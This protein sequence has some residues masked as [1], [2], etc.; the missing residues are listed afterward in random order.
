MGCAF[1][2]C[3]PCLHLAYDRSP[4]SFVPKHRF[5]SMTDDTLRLGAYR[6]IDAYITGH[7]QLI[8]IASKLG[9]ESTRMT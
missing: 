6:D 9:K 2:L 1:F 3:N 4:L 5:K 7:P 8:G